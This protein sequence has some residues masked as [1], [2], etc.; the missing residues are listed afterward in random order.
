[1]N[2]QLFSPLRHWT[3]ENLTFFARPLS[4]VRAY[5]RDALWP[6]LVAGA[7]VAVVLLPQ[8]IA[9]A[10]V[11]ELPP[12][13]GLY[14]AIVAPI[15]GALWG[16]SAHLHTGPTNA[17]SLLVLS[18]LLPIAPPGTE[19][20]V[21]AAGLMAVMVGVIRLAMGLARLGVLVNFVSDAVIIGFTAS[22]GILIS[23]N[24]LRHLLRLSLPGT[25]RFHETLVNLAQNLNNTHWPSLALGSGA[26]LTIVLTRRFRP[27]W[28]AA[29]LAM[30]LTAVCVAVLD[31][32]EA[33]VIV[34]GQLP[35]GLPP[36][37][38]LP[39]QD[40]ALMGELSAGAMAVAAIGL[41]EAMSIARSIAAQS[42]Q[43]LD[44]NQ[45]FV[46]QGLANIFT[47]MLSGYPCSGSFTRSSVNYVRRRM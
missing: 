41:V 38:A 34:L 7:T 22:A 26:I 40:L 6:D 3:R 2:V 44:S 29:L 35:R 28:P 47:G 31:L 16:S 46:G 20:Y 21:A 24:Q 27:Q 25:T 9:Y 45:E 32:E 5:R 23:A 8:A 10:L 30:V 37:A 13:V 15:V 43:R 33:G 14:A 42:G 17:A 36:L 1:M 12:Q 19:E 39:W 18:S 4:V 11:A